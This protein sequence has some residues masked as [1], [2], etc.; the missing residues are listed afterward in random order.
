[1]LSNAGILYAGSLDEFSPATFE[2]MTKVNYIGYYHCVKYASEVMKIQ[3]SYNKQYFMDIIQVNSKS[4]LKGVI[5]ISHI[6]V[7]IRRYRAY[8][9]FCA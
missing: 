5:K 2:L 9:V 8:P 6:P 7:Q 1:M 3:W 4:G